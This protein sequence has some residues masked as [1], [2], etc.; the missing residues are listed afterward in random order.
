M[1]FLSRIREALHTHSK[2]RH[3][4][5]GLLVA[6]LAGT[7][8]TI[9]GAGRSGILENF[10]RQTLDRR[11]RTYQLTRPADSPIVVVEITDSDLDNFTTKRHINWPWS[12][13]A[14]ALA[15]DWFKA[16]GAKA[17]F[18]DISLEDGHGRFPEK[19]VKLA[20]SM[21]ASG[22]VFLLATFDTP[23]QK[24][25][26]RLPA[27]MSRAA[28]DAPPWMRVCATATAPM[29]EYL[30]EARGILNPMY[31]VKEKDPDGIARRYPVGVAFQGKAFLSPGVA[32]AAE[33]LGK[34]V[35]FESR[36]FRIGDL[37]VPVDSDG[38]LQ[39]NWTVG[40]RGFNPKP[41]TLGGVIDNAIAL[42]SKKAALF[43]YEPADFKDKVVFVGAS[44]EGLFDLKVTPLG[45]QLG[46]ELHAMATDTILKIASVHRVSRGLTALGT[47]GLAL[48]A[49]LTAMTFRI[50]WSVPLAVL[51]GA[52][53]T[54]LAW[55]LL[56]HHHIWLDLVHPLGALGLAELGATLVNYAV[57]GRQRRDIRNK[58]GTYLTPEYVK[59]LEDDPS[60]FKLGGEERVGTAFF[61]D[62]S[63]FTA[64]SEKMTAGELV[65]RMNEYL[66]LMTKSIKRFKG[67]VDKYEGDAI[68]AFWNAP[69]VQPDHAVLACRAALD[70]QKELAGLRERWIRDYGVTVV[71]RIG[72]NTGKMIFGNMGSDDK[73]NYTMM[74]DPVNLAARLE[75]ANKDYAT[76]MMIGADTYE[77]VKDAMECRELDLLKVKGKQIP[78]TVYELL[79]EKGALDPRTRECMDRYNL[80]LQA[81]RMKQ[82]HAA[83]QRFLEALEINPNDGPSKLYVERSRSL[84]AKPPE[85]GWTYVYEKK[86]K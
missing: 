58:F 52:A 69:I 82:F 34:P 11:F 80:G 5:Q 64:M 30:P 25:P 17:V 26:E 29:D 77:L 84:V 3:L 13:E 42:K 66:T 35:V 44:A 75:S 47:F 74:G 57:E 38:L 20:D 81:Y 36:G 65:A 6:L 53:W 61:S 22:N 62:L 70:N 72:L 10:E 67:T 9:A 27:L 85:P 4:V 1:K 24:Y 31:G 14:Y 21:K 33:I 63:G 39:V 12:R 43:P 28:G 18:F 41:Y 55:R 51:A 16:A 8:V 50:R 79:C 19:D 60:L 68:V 46:V 40:P 78:V 71:A 2:A 83:E 15:T 56:G 76:F 73:F 23:L 86:D 59:L 49:G 37:F 54:A 32:L 45:T 48:F 7:A